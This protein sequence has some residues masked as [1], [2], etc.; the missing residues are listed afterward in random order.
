M[1]KSVENIFSM[2]SGE[3]IGSVNEPID[4]VRSK[5]ALVAGRDY[6]MVVEGGTHLM[7]YMITGRATSLARE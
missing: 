1:T 7:V 2:N 5:F 6:L 4:S 3:Q